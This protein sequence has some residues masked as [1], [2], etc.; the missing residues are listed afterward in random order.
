MVRLSG[1]LCPRCGAARLKG[2][3][4]LSDEEKMLAERL[5]RSAE[6]TLEERK[7]HRFCTRCWFETK[8]EAALA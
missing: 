2:W 1:K 4:E 5:P 6:E 3:P 7:R 8:D